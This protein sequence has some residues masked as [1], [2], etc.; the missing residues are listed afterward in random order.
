MAA[1]VD[2][3]E[4]AA[5]EFKEA[6]RWYFERSTAIAA[7]FADEVIRAV[8]NIAE[9]PHR[10]PAQIAGTRKFVMH[11]FPFLIIYREA[12]SGIQILAV[13]HAKRRP[14]YWRSRL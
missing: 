2:F 1:E 7:E 3:H 13:A 12:A 6:F 4:E 10:W 8:E 9:A 14:G 11:R 5:A